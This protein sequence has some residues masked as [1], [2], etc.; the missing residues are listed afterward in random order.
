MS[1]FDYH[2]LE[3]NRL[4]AA[5]AAAQGDLAHIVEALRTSRKLSL[6]SGRKASSKKNR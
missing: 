4:R 1:G 6:C 2:Q 3:I 5:L